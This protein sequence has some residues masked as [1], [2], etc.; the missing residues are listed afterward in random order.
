M[1]EQRIVLHA[2]ERHH[3]YKIKQ[4]DLMELIVFIDRL[5]TAG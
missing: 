1:L 2:G 5:E 4:N 3:R